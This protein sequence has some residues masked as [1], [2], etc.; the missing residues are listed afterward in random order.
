MIRGTKRPLEEVRPTVMADFRASIH[1]RFDIEVVDA[2]TGEIKNKAV[3]HN[4]ICN[5]FWT[6]V[7][8]TSP[9]YFQYIH[10]GNGSG[11]PSAVDTKLFSFLGY[12]SVGDPTF[13]PDFENGVFAIRK[14]AQINESTAV[15]AT[16]TEVGI[17]Y[18]DSETSLVTHAMLRD[19]NGNPVSITKTDTDIIN[20]Y[21]T[22]F[23]HYNP[24]GYDNG[25]VKILAAKDNVLLAKMLA[26]ISASS[27]KDRLA[28]FVVTA[29]AL[30][31]MPRENTDTYAYG[32]V[33]TTYDVANR[34]MLVQATRLPVGSYNLSG[35]IGR[36][37]IGNQATNSS[38][39]SSPT[40]YYFIRGA[41]DVKVGGSWFGGSS[42]TGEA[43]ATG[44]GVTTDFSTRFPFVSNAIIYVDGVPAG[45]ASVNENL[46]LSAGTMGQYFEL[47]PELSSA[48]APRPEVRANSYENTVG[49]YYNPFHEYG[50]TS[51][52]SS[53]GNLT[54]SVSDDL[55][56]WVV[57]SAGKSGA[58]SVPAEY[59]NYRYWKIEQSSRG[60]FYIHSLTSENIPTTNIHFSA[61]PAA[62]AVITADYF[63]KV[64]AKDENHVFDLTVTIQ[65]GEYTEN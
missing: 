38:G 5:Q 57:L 33:T 52:Y 59:Q 25:T 12:L 32:S 60:S 42:V 34:R 1:N 37:I 26:G 51:Y 22:V 31:D 45:N 14:L 7:L 30:A 29:G 17:A 8:S 6:K 15:G 28:H 24:E 27:A 54:V 41:L 2:K 23:I 18:S 53:S 58:Y 16:L 56:D 13:I 10:Y 11:T 43:V 65:L 63:T 47:I 46:P 61:P 21:A 64:V 50:I 49:V 55:E 39:G 4:T 44:D 40:T 20:V 62:G 35:G 36:V 9:T 3:A 48:L 19:M